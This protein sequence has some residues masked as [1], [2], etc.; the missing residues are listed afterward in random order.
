MHSRTRY[1]NSLCQRLLTLSLLLLAMVVLNAHGQTPTDSVTVSLVTFYPGEESFSIY[2]HTE[3]RVQ[4]N[5]RDWYYNYGVFDF[6]ASGFVWRFVT[7]DAEYLCVPIPAKYALLDMEG[8]R[9]VEQQLNLTQ[10]EAQ[11]VANMLLTNALP[12][13]RAYHYR[14]LTDNCS[15][16]P[17]DI[18]ETAVADDALHYGDSP[19]PGITYRQMLRHYGQNYAWQQFGIELV[20]GST[21]DHP[22]DYREQMFIPMVLMQAA[23]GATV[24]RDG[25]TE[26]LVSHTQVV[27]DASEQGLVLP[28]TP[29][30]C[31][32]LA[33]TLLL[34]AVA[35]LL[36]V[37]DLHQRVVTRWFDSLLF[38]ILAIIGSIITFLVLC[39]EHEALWPNWNL[40]WAHPLAWLPAVGVW[41]LPRSQRLLTLYHCC[42][43]VMM[44][45]TLALWPIIP[46]CAHIA[47][48]PL[49]A[50]SALRSVS[51]VAVGRKARK[52]S[53]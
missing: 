20:L 37:R 45:F 25:R 5:D 43:A 2:G 28:P 23:E 44:V 34:L 21:L 50:A 16:R 7:G 53:H 1:R 12:A 22:L 18:I 27:V 19:L 51:F 14:Y 31:S 48:F 29:W 17:R 38:G 32:P 35:V 10:A 3:L 39:S 9:M 30:W 24:T 8:R 52:A 26:P 42:N 4:Q 6:E 15:T 11:R 47:F 13:N 41:L 33:A 36:T 49:M 40:L 46:Q